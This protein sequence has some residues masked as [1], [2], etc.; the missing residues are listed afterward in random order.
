MP[1]TE[2]Q[3]TAVQPRSNGETANLPAEIKWD[4]PVGN[5]NALKHIIMSS[6]SALE[7]VLPKHMTPEKVVRLAYI[8]AARIPRI[9]E[10]TAISV[11]N[12]LITSSELGLDFTG[13]LG[14]GYPIPY[15]NKKT[16]KYELQ[17]LPGYRGYIKLARNSGQVSTIAAHVVYEGEHFEIEYGL[18]DKLVH[19][20]DLHPA[21][22][23]NRVVFGAYAV[24]RFKDGSHDFE[25]MPLHE[26]EAIRDRSQARNS[27]PW[28]TDTTEMYR[29]TVIRRLA[30]RLPLSPELEALRVYDNR[31]DGIDLTAG[32][33]MADMVTNDT[34]EEMDTNDRLLEQMKNSEAHNKSEAEPEH[35]PEKS[36][37][38]TGKEKALA[39]LAEMSGSEEYSGIPEIN[40]EFQ[41]LGE[42]YN[43]MT[44]TELKT[45]I[46]NIKDL[47]SKHDKKSGKSDQGKLM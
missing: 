43:K 44:E 5:T 29:K 45:A 33:A 37:K 47:K 38:L 25:F 11:F 13:T 26:L 17:Y 15:W 35:E 36:R 12:S 21:D 34:E 8:A 1:T 28:V 23:K 30:K 19:K 42:K 3:T 32:A 20:P 9:T 40:K 18:E 4:K 2:K 10:C 14:E 31:V 41:G 16:Q 24:V 6:R 39:E 22:P 27:G 7:K 46:A